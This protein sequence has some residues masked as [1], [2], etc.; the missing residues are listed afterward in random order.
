MHKTLLLILPATFLIGCTTTE[1]KLCQPVPKYMTTLP[2]DPVCRLGAEATNQDV[3][4]C[5]VRVE[6][7]R[8]ALKS[9][10]RRID[11]HQKPC[12]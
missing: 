7:N 10:L 6:R 12:R 1:P 5:I 11:I 3:N 4:I 2:P 8:Q 9:K